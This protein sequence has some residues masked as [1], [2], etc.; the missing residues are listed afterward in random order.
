MIWLLTL[1][2]AAPRFQWQSDWNAAF[3][4]AKQQHK[5][6]FVDYFQAPCPKCIDIEHLLATDPALERTLSDF[7]LLR[8]NVSLTK[9]PPAYQ[10]TPPAY[11]VFDEDRRERL[12]IRESNGVLRADDWHFSQKSFSEP[13]EGIRA[14]KPA[15]VKVA[16][17]FG[18]KRDLDANFL[19]A[20]TYHRL[21]MTEHA[22]AAFAEAKKVAERQGKKDIAQSAEVQSAYTYVTEGR[23]PHA[24]ELLKPLAKTP[25]NRVTEAVIWLTLGHAY[26]AATDKADAVAAFRRAQSLAEEGTR[27]KKEATAALARLK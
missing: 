9:I 26:E 8:V 3:A 4:L 2:L 6:V 23:A 14:A 19:L 12:L 11:V 10:H 5:L 16:E 13:I 21:K 27:T 25:V 18:A 1:I 17:L 20:T 7:I 24:V 15:F 22:R